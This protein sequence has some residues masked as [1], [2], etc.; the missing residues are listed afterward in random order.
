MNIE[1]YTAQLWGV[2][3]RVIT[4]DGVSNIIG[5]FI[6]L[7]LSLYSVGYTKKCIKYLKEAQEKDEYLDFSDHYQSFA[8]I[9]CALASLTLFAGSVILLCD[10]W[11]WVAVFHPD[12]YATHVIL[13]KFGGL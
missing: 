9:F 13:K 3:S 12:L 2:F 8:A 6:C 10:I 11:N 7:A 1:D 5:G 4:I